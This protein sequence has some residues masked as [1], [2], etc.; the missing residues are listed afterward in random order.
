MKL[1][2]PLQLYV[3]PFTG[4]AVS[5]SVLPAQRGLLLPAIG[6]VPRLLTITKTVAGLAVQPFCVTVTEYNPPAAVVTFGIVGFCK[7]ELN[8]L[9]PVHT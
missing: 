6:A 3:A 7:V 4:V 5:V 8:P 1:L 9:G 2:G